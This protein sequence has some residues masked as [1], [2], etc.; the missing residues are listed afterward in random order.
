MINIKSTIIVLFVILTFSGCKKSEESWSFCEGCNL[1]EWVGTYEGTGTY[2]KEAN[3][4]NDYDVPTTITIENPEGNLLSS[5]VIAGDYLNLGF[6]S[7]KSDDH[8]YY[9]IAG[10]VKTL[11]LS[12]SRKGNDLRLTGTAEEYKGNRVESISFEVFKLK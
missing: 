1:N 7:N 11:H 9:S 5:I 10:S 6:E 3:M 2:F 12:L 8:Y 4:F